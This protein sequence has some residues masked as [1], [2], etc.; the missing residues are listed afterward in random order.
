VRRKAAVL[1]ALCVALTGAAPK[2]TAAPVER[3]ITMGV[4]GETVRSDEH[5][6]VIGGRIY[7]PLRA[8][9]EAVG[10]DL[11]R[12]GNAITG[13]LPAGPLELT[14]GSTRAVLNG[15][16]VV[17]DGTVI[18]MKGTAYVPLRFLTQS[19]GADATYDASAA[20]VEIVSG[21]VGKNQG[22]SQSGAHGQTT[23]IG[24]VSAIDA[25]SQPPSITVVQAG[26][27]RTIAISSHSD[28]YI[29]D[30]SIHSQVKASLGDIRVGDALRAVLGADGS[31]LE[32][33]AFYRSLTGTVA[34]VS[35]ASFVLQDGRVIT[36]DRDTEI[37]LNAA[38]ASIG[39]IRVAD[40]VTVRSN[41]ESG[42]LRQIVAT[43]SGAATAPSTAVMIKTFT[44]TIS[45][46]L[47]AGDSFTV[48]MTGT[49]GAKATFDIA[50]V[51]AGQPMNE[52]SPGSYEGSF[53]IPDRFNV[54]EVPIYGRLTLGTE[55]AP[56]A[57]APQRLS[58]ATLPPQIPE[59]APRPGETIN[60]H[61]PNIY[62]T[63][64]VPSE[65]GVDPR[66]ISVVV[67]EHDVSAGSTRTRAFV[68]FSPQGD[69]PSGP[70]HVTIRVSDNAGNAGT[71]SWTFYIK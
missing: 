57:E 45:K 71:R 31:V 70:V 16:S 43:R 5:P 69:L 10:I 11:T 24:S 22:Q 12:R 51:V 23:V 29:E 55:S 46:P 26:S 62:G 33:H 20:R 28:V 19:L 15:R 41:P 35:P 68:T 65:I 7:V 13:T 37:T 64:F 58:S 50:D 42:K 53:R 66:T 27:A 67:N 63:F 49:P 59:V 30:T 60:N 9:F 25:N 34:A 48:S 1:A 40:L 44:T 2:P 4:N 52:V 21:F 14:V 18:D 38:P 17:L 39:D 32:V 54:A 6:R 56:R 61:R 36:P 3:Q 47:R 8:T